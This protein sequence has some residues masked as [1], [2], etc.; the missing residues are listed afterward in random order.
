MNS[1]GLC[2]YDL[3][4]YPQAKE[5]FSKSLRILTTIHLPVGNATVYFNLALIDFAEKK[6]GD[7]MQ[8][9]QAA[10][11]L[12]KQLGMETEAKDTLDHM[13][14]TRFMWE[15]EDNVLDPSE[16]ECATVDKLQLQKKQYLALINKI[17][18]KI[19]SI[20]RLRHESNKQNIPPGI[21]L[22]KRLM[23]QSNIDK[24]HKQIR[25]IKCLEKI[26]LPAGIISRRFDTNPYKKYEHSDIENDED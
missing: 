26:L 3:H 13:L 10:F 20:D 6:W 14:M 22:K 7:A 15:K 19:P 24:M 11:E 18:S 25:Q 12:H 2:Y 16:F 8:R 9:F 5:L 1:I 23:L 21:F 17:K 4:N